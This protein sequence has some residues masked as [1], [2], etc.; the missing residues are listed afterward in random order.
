[1]TRSD[2]DKPKTIPNHS[3]LNITYIQKWE[4]EMI[5]YAAAGC[6]FAKSKQTSSIFLKY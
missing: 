2:R 5:V 6:L 4:S 1:M 3:N